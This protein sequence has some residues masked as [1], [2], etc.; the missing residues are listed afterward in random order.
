MMQDIQQHMHRVIDDYIYV[1]DLNTL[2]KSFI[3]DKEK[4][5]CTWS[6]ITI[7]MHKML[8]G[9]SPHIHRLAAVTELV[10]LTLDIMDDL[11][12]QDQGSKP[13]MQCPQAVTLN[14][15]MALFMGVLGELGHLQVKDKLL[16][17]VSK[18]ISR[19]INGQ[20]KDVTN[21]ISTIDEYLMMTQEKSGSL[22]R[23]ACYMGYSS[24]E[25]SEETI[26]QIHQLADCIGLIHQIQND[27]RDLIRFDVKNDLI[28]RKRTLPV[29][30]LLSIEDTAFSQL[31]AYYEGEI[32]VNFLLEEKEDFLQMIHD[33]GCMEYARIV[34]SVCMQK[35]EEIYENL[36]A[37][38]PWKERFKQM[39]YEDFL[40]AD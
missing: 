10:I 6:K 35:A 38:S 26:E 28:G 4:E 11:Q 8:G 9:D 29:L 2:L 23:L 34:Q 16:V 19:S 27:M 22:Y 15:V 39:T 37:I 31:K 25:C 33:S 30:Y 18:I 17:E 14:A 32:T 5:N 12:D 24:L 1:E 7:C 13:W 21:T 3:D 40:D 20:Q 36:Q